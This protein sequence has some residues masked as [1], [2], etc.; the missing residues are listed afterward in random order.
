MNRLLQRLRGS[1][2]SSLF[3]GNLIYTISQW[4]IVVSISKLGNVSMVGEY[5]LALAITAPIILFLNFQLRN[6]QAT[7]AKN[8]YSFKDYLTLRIGMLI[9]AFIILISISILSNYSFHQAMIILTIGLAKIIESISDIYFGLFQKKEH[10]NFISYSMIT[11]GIGSVLVISLVLYWSQNLLYATGS[12]VIIWFLILVFVD[13]KNQSR[14]IEEKNKTQFSKSNILNL[15]RLLQMTLPLGIVATLDS[16][17]NNIP[18]YFLER[19]SGPEY[20]GYYSGIAY[21]M[22]A[23]GTFMGAMLQASSPSMSRLFHSDIHLF[24]KKVKKLTLYS[25]MIGVFGI[26]I[27]ASMGK[28]ILTLMYN[29]EYGY[30]NNVFILIMI[31]SLFWYISSTLGAALT[32]SRFIKFQVPIFLISGI[33]VL[34]FSFILIPR[35]NMIGAAICIIIGMMTRMIISYFCLSFV[36]K[37]ESYTKASS[38]VLSEN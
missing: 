8:E 2:F 4:L 23:G 29:R 14:F 30:F 1:N 24:S 31:A 33:L 38:V 11:K 22:I 28:W 12:M 21:I 20:L 35:Y 6:F 27:S 26:L 32:A 7:D 19:V 5:S 15:K 36:L 37:R 9:I 34:L 10:M 16:L 18:R 25:I 3:I 17:I 13:I